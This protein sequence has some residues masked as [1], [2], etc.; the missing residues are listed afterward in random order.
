MDI[1]TIKH[2]INNNKILYCFGYENE[3]SKTD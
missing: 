3:I 2:V 1:N